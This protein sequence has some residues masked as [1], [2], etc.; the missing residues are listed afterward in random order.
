MKIHAVS[1]AD[2]VLFQSS[3]F[4]QKM[5]HALLIV[6]Q[7]LSRC[8]KPYIAFSSGKDSLAT[9]ALV[10]TLAPDVPAVWSDDELEL[11]ETVEY[12]RFVQSVSG[13]QLTITLGYAQHAG[14]FT[15]WRDYPLWR[16]PLPS[17][18]EI[19]MDVDAWQ[20]RRGYDLVFTGLRMSENVRRQAWL[21]DRGP[22]YK[23]GSDRRRQKQSLPG[24]PQLGKLRGGS[25][26]R[27]CPIWDWSEDDV[28]ALIA[29]LRLKYNPA[30]D[31]MQQ[32]DYPRHSQRVGPL[33]LARRWQL[34]QAWPEL[35]DR[36]E[37]RYGKRWDR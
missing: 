2:H 29:G 8:R 28:W 6:E 12:M 26:L 4:R 35:L 31:V 25:R 7:A 23:V 37:T 14:W 18:I 19:G 10:Q 3:Q 5:Q 33:P 9:L 21:A 15:P 22:I 11:P 1:E 17:A 20:A 36:L 16:D 27:C 13:D 32:H 24:L 34:E 30:Y